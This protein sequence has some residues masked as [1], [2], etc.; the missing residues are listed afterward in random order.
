MINYRERELKKQT[1]L[2][3]GK[4]KAVGHSLNCALGTILFK[5]H[6]VCST[7]VLGKKK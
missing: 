4:L 1:D 6:C 3:V 2:Q 5:R 7:K